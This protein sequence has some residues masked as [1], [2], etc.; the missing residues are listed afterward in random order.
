MPNIAAMDSVWTDL[1][2]AW[3][4]ATKG[5]V[6]ATKARVAFTVAARNIKAKL[7]G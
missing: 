4:K 7:R 5:A 6:A 3:V 2:N 1:G